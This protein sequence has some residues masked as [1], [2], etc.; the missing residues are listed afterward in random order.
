MGRNPLGLISGIPVAKICCA[1]QE[2]CRARRMSEEHFQIMA[3]NDDEKV[4]A[5]ERIFLGDFKGHAKVTTHC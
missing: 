3:D 2:A 4:A 5:L 1:C